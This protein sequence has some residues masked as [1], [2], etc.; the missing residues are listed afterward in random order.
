MQYQQ[1]PTTTSSPSDTKQCRR[2]WYKQLNKWA[3]RRTGV[4]ENTLTLE[5]RANSM[6]FDWSHIAVW[7]AGYFQIQGNKGRSNRCTGTI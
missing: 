6:P 2:H 1:A 3:A 5:D 7:L 4:R